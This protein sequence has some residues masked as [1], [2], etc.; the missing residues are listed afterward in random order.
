MKQRYLEYTIEQLLEEKDFIAWAL[1]DIKAGEWDDFLEKNPEFYRKAQKAREIIGLINEKHEVLDEDSLLT[2]WMDIDRYNQAQKQKFKKR[3][4]WHKLSWAASVLLI[5]SIGIGG[6][7]YLEKKGEMYRF[8]SSLNLENSN[9]HM[10]LSS[11]KEISLEQKHSAIRLNDAEKQVI[12][13]DRI[14]DLAELEQDQKNK[15]ELNEV[16]IP[17]G[18]SSELLL[19]DGTKVWLNAGSRLAFPSSFSDDSREVYLE[20]EACFKVA[21][22]ERKP[23]IVKTGELDVRVL[24]TFFNVSAYP[25]DEVVETVLI[26][27]SVAVS[28]PKMLGL[29]RKELILTPDQKASFRKDKESITVTNEPDV[30]HYISWT[31]GWLEYSRESLSDVLRKVERYYNVTFQMPDNYPSDDRI[32]GKLDLE[33][34]LESVLIVLGDASGYNYRVSG[35]QVLVEKKMKIIPRRKIMKE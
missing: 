8:S 17:Y 1:N 35:N 31:N 2:M 7:L 18:K 16:I 29:S 30:D 33:T 20:G 15:T 21:R 25:A 5:L 32:S 28:Q 19:A 4:L 26:E 24:G 23:F 13:N 3:E 34:S 11:G 10:V 12:V 6:Y 27:G 22:N 9:G 14:I